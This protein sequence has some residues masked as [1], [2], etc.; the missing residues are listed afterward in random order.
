MKQILEISVEVKV[1][2]SRLEA[3][4]GLDAKVFEVPKLW[5]KKM[6]SIWRFV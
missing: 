1:M 6:I 3:D 2:Q 4:W 5:R